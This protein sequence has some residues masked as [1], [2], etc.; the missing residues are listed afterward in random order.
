MRKPHARSTQFLLAESRYSTSSTQ[1]W[2][3]RDHI[4]RTTLI[5]ECTQFHACDHIT[6]PHYTKHIILRSW[7]P[8]KAHNSANNSALVEHVTIPCS[9]RQYKALRGC[10]GRIKHTIPRLRSTLQFHARGDN[11]KHTILRL[12]RPHKAHN[13]PLAEHITI[14]CSWRQ[15]KAHYSTF[16]EHI[17]IPDLR[18]TLQFHAR[19]NNTKYTIPRLRRP[20]KAHNF[21]LAE[22]ITYNSTI[23]EKYKAHNSALEDA[24]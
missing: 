2:T 13:S 17:T 9:W 10:G 11:K 19:G 22:Y 15:Y 7:R 24:T 3:H 20:H 4:E 5:T 18:S 16:A 1:F 14:P 23:V 12:R 8:H 21:A 6:I